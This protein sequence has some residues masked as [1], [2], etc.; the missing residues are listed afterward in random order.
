MYGAARYF[1]AVS[2]ELSKYCIG[3]TWTYSRVEGN[4]TNWSRTRNAVCS[5]FHRVTSVGG[6]SS[7]ITHIVG[8][9]IAAL[10]HYNALLSLQFKGHRFLQAS[11][12]FFLCSGNKNT[13]LLASLINNRMKIICNYS[14]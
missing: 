7:N 10:F 1:T 6:R 11:T 5:S 2:P 8:T 13:P 4:K 9:F 3:S 14:F 12:L